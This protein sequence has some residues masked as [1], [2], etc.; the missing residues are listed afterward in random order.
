MKYFELDEDITRLSAAGSVVFKTINADATWPVRTL[1]FHPSCRT[2]EAFNALPGKGGSRLGLD[3]A[4]NAARRLTPEQY[5]D[6]IA[7]SL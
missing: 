1:V 3:F 5:A 7:R 6:C 2:F 4:K